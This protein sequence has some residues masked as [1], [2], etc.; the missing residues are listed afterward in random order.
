MKG[1][2]NKQK[3]PKTGVILNFKVGIRLS[4][5]INASNKGTQTTPGTFFE[6]KTHSHIV[7]KLFVTVS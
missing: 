1:E 3:S 4:I 7:Q 6:C 5:K 2:R